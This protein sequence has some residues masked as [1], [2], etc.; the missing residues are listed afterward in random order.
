MK[1]LPTLEIE[2]ATSNAR[3]IEGTIGLLGCSPESQFSFLDLDRG[4]DP[5][6]PFKVV[7]GLLSCD[8]AEDPFLLEQVCPQVDKLND[9]RRS[10]GVMQGFP[11]KGKVDVRCGQRSGSAVVQGQGCLVR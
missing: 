6:F 8:E 3:G 9:S 2:P 10:W 4:V 5:L 11:R 7:G 1:V